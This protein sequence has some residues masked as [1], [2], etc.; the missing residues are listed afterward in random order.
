MHRP[1]LYPD[2]ARLPVSDCDHGL[3][4]AQGA[5]VAAVAVNFMTSTRRI[6]H[7]LPKQRSSA[8]ANTTVSHPRFGSGHP[9]N[10][11]RFETHGPAIAG[12][13]EQ[14]PDRDRQQCH[15]ACSAGRR[16]RTEELL[17]CGFGF[18]RGA[19]CSDVQPDWLGQAQRHRS[20]SLSIPT[21]LHGSSRR[22]PYHRVFQHR[23]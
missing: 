22:M 1:H 2:G 8:S 12:S 7:R 4:H 10:G 20:G 13:L 14:W 5:V 16:S 23:G 6:D 11:N 19:G 21:L 17:V 3:V 15:R 18:S 9:M